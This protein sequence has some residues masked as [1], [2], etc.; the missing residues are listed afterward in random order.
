MAQ[1]TVGS[2]G[3]GERTYR[4]VKQFIKKQTESAAEKKARLEAEAKKKKKPAISET[5]L[6][7]AI[8]AREK[9]LDKYRKAGVI[10]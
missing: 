5:G 4:T 2:P 6:L 9:E 10:P 8:P 1:Q 7:R 3:W